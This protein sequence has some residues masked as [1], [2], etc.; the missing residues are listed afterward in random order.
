MSIEGRGMIKVTIDTYHRTSKE[1]ISTVLE[2][3]DARAA[4]NALSGYCEHRFIETLKVEYIKPNESACRLC[5]EPINTDHDI[6]ERGSDGS[7][8]CRTC[9]PQ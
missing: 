6:F 8:F 4:L 1:P 7:I 3:P 5:W 9:R 2:Y